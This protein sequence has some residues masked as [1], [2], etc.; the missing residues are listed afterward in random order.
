MVPAVT[1]ALADN[2]LGDCSG[3][4]G[5]II[6]PGGPAVAETARAPVASPLGLLGL[7]GLLSGVSAVTLR[8]QTRA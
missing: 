3:V 6:D 8:R 4:V 7:V 1:F 2:Q 5:T